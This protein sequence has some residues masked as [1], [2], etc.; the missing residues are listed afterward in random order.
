MKSFRLLFALLL[1]AGSVSATQTVI[2]TITTADLPYTITTSGTLTDT[3]VYLIAGAKITSATDG[4]IFPAN[5]QY[6]MIDGQGDTLAFGTAGNLP[7]ILNVCANGDAGTGDKGIYLQGGVRNI[8][9][10]N[11]KIWH[12]PPEV[13][14]DPSREVQAVGIRILP[15]GSNY[16]KNST[17]ED[18]RI[19]VVGRHS[20][21][22]FNG[23]GV[24]N[25][26]YY[27]LSFIDSCNSY[28][29][30]DYWV[31]QTMVNFTGQNLAASMGA[32]FQYH[33]YFRECTTLVAFWSNYHIEGDS[34]V[35]TF[36]K[37]VGTSDG[38]NRV[39]EETA[40]R[41]GQ[42][43]TATENFIWAFRQGSASVPDGCKIM[44][45]SCYGYSGS[46]HAGCRGVF[47]SGV[48]GLTLDDPLRS[49]TI[50]NSTFDL[51]QGWDGNNP[52]C[53]FA[54]NREGWGNIRYENNKI[55]IRG[56]R[57]A[58]TTSYGSQIIGWDL[59]ST[60]GALDFPGDQVGLLIKNNTCS[61]YFSDADRTS[62]NFRDGANDVGAWVI[63]GQ[64]HPKQNWDNIT[65]TNNHFVTNGSFYTM[66]WYNGVGSGMIFGPNDTLEYY[67]AASPNDNYSWT[68]RLGDHG[69]NTP[70]DCDSNIMKDLVFLKGV[71]DDH[72][73]VDQPGHEAHKHD[74]KIEYTI[75]AQVLGSN[76]L[77]V[78]N[79]TFTFQDGYG[80]TVFTGATGVNGRA[81]GTVPYAWYT[82]AGS[83]GGVDSNYN[84]YTIRVTKGA[85][86]STVLLPLAWNNK[87]ILMA[88]SATRGFDSLTAIT[89]VDNFPIDS[90]TS[91]T[92]Y[93]PLANPR[94]QLMP[95]TDSGSFVVYTP[96]GISASNLSLHTTF[97]L[98]STVPWVNV[99][100]PVASGNSEHTNHDHWNVYKDTVFAVA[101]NP[102]GDGNAHYRSFAYSGPV[103]DSL[104]ALQ[105]A[106]WGVHPGNARFVASTVRLPNS[107]IIISVQRNG[108]EAPSGKAMNIQW[109]R[110]IDKG[111]TWGAAQY[112]ENWSSSV[113]NM[114]IGTAIF[115]NTA[116]VLIDSGE[117]NLRVYLYNRTSNTMDFWGKP[118]NWPNNTNRFRCL[119][120]GTLNDTILFAFHSTHGT[121]TPPYDTLWWTWRSVNG[122]AW[123]TPKGIQIGYRGL[124]GTVPYA[125][126]TTTM[127][128]STLWL[129]HNGQS[130]SL[131]PDSQNMYIRRFNADPAVWD[132]G[133]PTK[134][135]LDNQ[136]FNWKISTAQFIPKSHGRQL[137]AQYLSRRGSYYMGTIAR[138]TYA[139]LGALG[140]PEEPPVDPPVD[141]PVTPDPGKSKNI[142]IGT[143]VVFK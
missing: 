32:D 70:N 84:P 126:F 26:N 100:Y 74:M 62:Q 133:P 34:S 35:Y 134:V 24:Y 66:G 92:R 125:A 116:A 19:K 25:M 115:N 10:R 103:A 96:T 12:D 76:G 33:G 22:I 11:L 101:G 58:G 78:P 49:V 39:M 47:I 28:I 121:S 29:R 46:N 140:V 81:S 41:C 59:T 119:G 112:V 106:N 67:G 83:N 108:D 61:V 139:A 118:F 2:R 45:D 142:R 5:T 87:S 131:S 110:S 71:D 64:E 122:V 72:V 18:C 14:R 57:D 98:D 69:N 48:Q 90:T 17:I 52:N 44:V 37:C 93:D 89:A 21:C 68:A 65:T 15:Q 82:N 124:S 30:R 75:G 123:A 43:T 60:T 141:P 109:K 94:Y 85:D 23:G 127:F 42:Y 99:R 27:R 107:D 63:I 13:C 51:H 130:S 1:L 6:V 53:Y 8:R 3:A 136:V 4:I 16:V 77:P 128:D 105:D 97:N 20:R 132:F 129:W 56:D 7:A 137:Y 135:S 104:Y 138:V 73:Y 9:I 120:L 36:K 114:R 117:F 55:K 54:K 111:Q 91:A 50:R 88:L 80:R 102:G 38:W 79:A 86:V 113:A 31:N 40:E 143:G 95:L